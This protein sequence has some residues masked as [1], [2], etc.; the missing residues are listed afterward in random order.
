MNRFKVFRK[1]EVRPQS[2]CK[3]SERDHVT[4]IEIRTP[5]ETLL[6]FAGLVLSLLLRN[7]AKAEP[8]AIK[9]KLAVIE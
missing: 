6:L 7:F 3:A 4:Q 1:P 8:M 5:A 2:A 9:T